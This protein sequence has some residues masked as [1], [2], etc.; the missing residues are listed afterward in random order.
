MGVED[1]ICFTKLRCLAYH[2]I[3]QNTSQREIILIIPHLNEG[4]LKSYYCRT[5][6]FKYSF[7]PYAI[8]EWNKLDLQIRKAD[9][10]LSFKNVLLK[11]GH[12]VPNS[13][14]N[15]HNPVGLKLLTR[16]RIGLSHLNEHT[17]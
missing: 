5:D 9:S 13:Y 7:F 6:V 3:C 16:L 17:F 15:I 1:Y 12:P 11:I 10:L 8:S 4:G 2:Y 14:F